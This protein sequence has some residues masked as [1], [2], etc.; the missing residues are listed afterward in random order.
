MKVYRQMPVINMACKM[1]FT[2]AYVQVSINKNIGMNIKGN[3]VDN[4]LKI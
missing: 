2:R 3:V 4:T 1:K